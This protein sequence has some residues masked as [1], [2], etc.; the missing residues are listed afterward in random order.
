MPGFLQ[1]GFAGDDVLAV[2]GEAGWVAVGGIDVF[3][4]DGTA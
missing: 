2:V 1:W 3:E 4:G